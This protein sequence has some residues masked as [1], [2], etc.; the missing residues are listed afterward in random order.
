MACGSAAENNDRAKHAQNHR[1]LN[2]NLECA[3]GLPGNWQRIYDH[4]LEDRQGGAV[5]FETDIL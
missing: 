3:S 1:C 2:A 5:P 4:S